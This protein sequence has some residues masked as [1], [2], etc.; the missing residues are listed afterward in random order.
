MVLRQ[1]TLFF[2]LL[3]A[4]VLTGAGCNKGGSTSTQVR[5][6]AGAPQTDTTA[7]AGSTTGEIPEEW[8]LYHVTTEI[9]PIEFSFAL[10]NSFQA[11]VIRGAPFSWDGLRYDTLDVELYDQEY[12]VWVASFGFS[13]TDNQ[14]L[15]PVRD[16]M[17]NHR[18]PGDAFT[19]AEIRFGN[20]PAY[21]VNY[22]PDSLVTLEDMT[23]QATTIMADLSGR[24]VI[25]P[26]LSQDHS[27][28]EAAQV[29]PEEFKNM[30]AQY[31]TFVKGGK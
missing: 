31:F 6:D 30:V 27:V 16:W 9:S 25:M 7:D 26:D 29:D 21:T 1:F 12:G 22:P 19:I 15:I 3:V 24:W 2:V 17:E 28:L 5:T 14:D 23:F 8:T 18:L 4:L 13:I 10:P 20:Y 11:R